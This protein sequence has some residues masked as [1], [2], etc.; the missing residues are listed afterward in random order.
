MKMSKNLVRYEILLVND[1]SGQSWLRLDFQ[2]Y[3]S[4]CS[5]P[6]ASWEEDVNLGSQNDWKSSLI[7]DMSDFFLIQGFKKV[8][9]IL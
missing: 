2:P 5:L 3:V 6:H 9:Y 8:L 1:A 4:P 7:L